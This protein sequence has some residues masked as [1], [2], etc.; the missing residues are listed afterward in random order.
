MRKKLILVYP[1]QKWLKTDNN[2]TWN[3][4]PATLC[5]LGAMVREQVEVE[6]I[7]AQFNN[8]SEETFSEMIS[9][10]RPDYVGISVLSSEYGETLD[11]TAALVKRVDFNIVV[12]AGGIHPTIEYA[13]VI[14]NPN[15]DYIVRG[16]GEYVLQGLLKYLLGANDSLPTE[17]L[18]Y[19]DPQGNVVAQCQTL[20]K[21]LVKLP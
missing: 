4:N 20:V 21:D 16:E 11:I 18:V 2:T 15:I 17:G 14:K 1:N 8:F 6:V 9:L 10:S 19:R 12:I 7:D 3:L 5:I 13:T